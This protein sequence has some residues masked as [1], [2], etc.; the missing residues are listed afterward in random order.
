VSSFDAALLKFGR[1]YR[2]A[3]R[4]V[5]SVSQLI[6]SPSTLVSWP[7]LFRRT[8]RDSA[9]DRFHSRA[10][11]DSGLFDWATVIAYANDHFSGKADHHSTLARLYEVSFALG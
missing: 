2:F 6:G 5:K 9:M 3:S 11:R 1:R 10:F 8:L 4:Y 7:D